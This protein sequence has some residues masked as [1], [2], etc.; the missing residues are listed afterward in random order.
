MKNKI[1]LLILFACGFGL[2][3]CGGEQ[4]PRVAPVSESVRQEPPMII[5]D[6]SEG[7]IWS[8]YDHWEG[9]GNVEVHISIGDNEYEYVTQLSQSLDFL[10]KIRPPTVK[11]N[12][13]GPLSAFVGEWISTDCTNKK[14]STSDLCASTK[15]TI[16]NEHETV[17]SIELYDEFG[18][19]TLI[20]FSKS[21]LSKISENNI[22]ITTKSGEFI[23]YKISSDA[24]GNDILTNIEANGQ[25]IATF[26]R[27][28]DS[29]FSSEGYFPFGVLVAE[30][31]S[32]D[33]EINDSGSSANRLEA[34]GDT[35]A[36]M[37]SGQCRFDMSTVSDATRRQLHT[38]ASNDPSYTTPYQ[39]TAQLVS[40]LRGNG[41]ASCTD[42][43]RQIDATMEV[44]Q[45]ALAASD[46]LVSGS[47]WGVSCEAPS[48]RV[49][50]QT[51]LCNKS[52]VFTYT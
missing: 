30:A 31:Y 14:P 43:T 10:E 6:D 47:P 22:S 34:S 49:T 11:A 7:F 5:Y 13:N 37:T 9:E 40:E 32:D 24:K 1:P 45:S 36:V 42:I 35:S 8:R 44:H 21:K 19:A 2:T 52:C 15:I 51:A 39:T 25:T 46:A 18:T 28:E 26:A 4:S 23:Y 38:E 27:L 33:S 29:G 3:A 20:V 17:R 41:G 16:N 12:S 48:G 50:P